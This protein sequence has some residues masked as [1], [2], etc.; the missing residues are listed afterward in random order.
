MKA[1]IIAFV[2]LMAGMLTRVLQ[3]PHEHRP[4][5]RILTLN[6][7]T[8]LDDARLIDL[9]AALTEKNIAMCALQETRR[10]GFFTTSSSNYAIFTFGECSGRSGVGFAI[11]KRFAHLIISTRGVPETDG[12]LMVVDLLL[13]DANYPTQ[14][15]CAY[16]P[17]NTSP[18]ATRNKFYS[19]LETVTTSNSWLLG[20]FNARVGRR[21]SADSD[22]FGSVPSKT[23][24][25]WS[26]KN[27]LTPN[28]NGSMLLHVASSYNLRHVSS[29]FR[30]RDSK[31]WTWRHPRYR[32]RAVIDHIFVPVSHMRFFSRCYVPSDFSLSSDHRPVICELNFRPRIQPRAKMLP[33]L[34]IQLLQ[35]DES[36]KDAF[37]QNITA[38]LSDIDP[39]ALSSDELSSKIRTVAIESAHKHVPTKCKSKFPAEFT[40]ETIGLIRRKRELWKTMQ[41]SGMRIT[42]SCKEQYRS[43]CRETKH[44]IKADRNAKLEREAAELTDA[45]HQDTFKGYAMLK[46]QHQTRSKAVL[47]P[48]TDFTNHYRSHYE[49]GPESPVEVHGC[50]IP[51]SDSDETLT[52][53]DFDAGV[54]SLNSNRAAGQDNIAPEFIKHG[55]AVLLRW[56]FVLMSRLWSF[57]CELPLIDRIG[58]LL[59]IPKKAGGALVSCFRPICLLTSLYKLYA[60][61]LFHKVRNR[62]KDFVSWTQAG[63]IR[64]RSCANNLWIMRRVIERSIEF[65]V[66]VYCVLVDYKGAFDALNRTSLARILSLFLSPTMVRRVMCLYFDAK[67]NVRINDITGPVFQLFRGVR[68]GCPAS[69]S[70]FTVALSFVSWSFRTTY[71]GIRLV[72]FYL[73]SIEYADDQILFTLSSAGLQEMLTY[74]SDTAE[75]LGLR[76]APQKCELICFHLPG[77]INKS[78]LPVIKLGEH[79]VPW[80]ESVVYLGSRFAEDG[81]TLAAIKHRICCAE[82]IVKRLNSRVFRRRAVGGHLKGKFISSAVFASLMYGLQHCAISKRDQRCMDGFYLR[83]VKRVLFLPHDYHLSYVEAERRTGVSRPSQ[84]LAKERL[85]WT[86]H[87]LRSED[88]VLYEV[89]MFVPEGGRRGRGRPRLRFYDTVKEDLK[90]RGISINT[91]RQEDFWP[92]LAVRAADRA[93]W[94]TKVVNS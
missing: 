37:Q 24:G 6:C 55:G 86:G 93:T 63:F 51:T 44:A 71:K 5:T 91:K 18:A 41:T 76:L 40:T 10:D 82:T 92:A 58:C 13:H 77:T 20:D 17:T 87:V 43:I 53:D 52:Q 62:V 65:K 16:S 49:L 39:H 64:K 60:I 75:P 32:S 1:S 61:I 7:R 30:M 47:P 15:I 48:E 74:L 85:R 35:R 9:D 42:R 81:S 73:S 19:Q 84:Q 89:L 68:Q 27:D 67:A 36:V 70:F 4:R 12:R 90:A 72:T 25:P 69:P 28:A 23:V 59:P 2:L 11:H 88:K 45:F 14:L 8:L 54:R 83:L 34:D 79:I 94:R 29:H 78:L 21:L 38:S 50:D 80:K 31:R 66:P 57:S 33:P 22:A 46:R 56:V 26:L 3:R